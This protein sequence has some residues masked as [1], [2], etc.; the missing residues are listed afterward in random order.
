[1]SKVG[2]IVTVGICPCWDIVCQVDGLKWGQHKRLESQELVCAGKALN[3]SRALAWLKVK[4]IAAGLWGQSDYRQMVE[5]TKTISDFV[6]VRFTKAP[7]RTRQNITVVDSRAGREMH[8]RAQSKLAG[9]ESLRHLMADLKQIVTEDSI[10]VFAGS[11]PP[12]ELLEDCLSIIAKVRDAGAR[13]AV[14]TS[15]TALEEI[16]RLG[17]IWL[18]KPNVEELRQ[19]LGEQVADKTSAIVQAARRLCDKV[20]TIV[21]SRGPRGAAV[22]TRDTALQGRVAS[23][24]GKAA[25]TVGC[26]DYLLAGLLASVADGNDLSVALAKAVKVAA[27]R[28]YGL[29]E[30]TTWLEADGRIEARVYLP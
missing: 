23:G 6:D 8:L 24:S 26:G 7:G 4:S 22:L 9:K 1:M 12:G 3:I 21:V 20:Q 29:T 5:S 13:V 28:A 15:G 2:R 18:I 10:V 17:N 19:L 16:V 11:M 30:T 25:N 14:D 27:A